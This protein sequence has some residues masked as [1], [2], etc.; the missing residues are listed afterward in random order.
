MSPEELKKQGEKWLRGEIQ[1]KSFGDVVLNDKQTEFVNAK[2][3][4]TLM[5]GGFAS[6]KT[7]AFIIKLILLCLWF[8]GNRILLGRKTR[9]AVEQATLP[10]FFDICPPGI[11]QH[12]IGP[13]IIEFYNGS[14]ILLWGLDALQ[15]GAGQ[16]I[17]KAEQ[18]IKS[19]NLGAVFIDQLEEVE[20][21]VFEAL[22]GRLRRDVGFNQMNLTTN[23]ANFWAYDYFKA[24]PRKF[25]RL[26]E[27]SMMD[28]K[29]HLSDSFI[30]S[31]LE[32]PELYV[33]RYVYGEWSPDTLIQG[34]VFPEDYIKQQAFHVKKPIR[35]FDGIKIYEEPAHAE[36]QIGL[37][38]SEGSVDPGSIKVV[39]KDTGEEVA[40]YTAFVP[41]T[42][43]A[44]KAVQLGIMYSLVKKPLIVPESQG[45]GTAVIEHL[46]KLGYE[47]IYEREVF[48][49]REKRSTKK[50]GFHTNHASKT[51]LIEHL[52]ELFKKRFPK[53]RD[54]QTLEEMKTFIYSDEA[55]LKGAG[56][57]TG[58]HD[59]RVM[60]L[61]L[62]YWNIEAKTPKERNILERVGQKKK[63]VVQY[64]YD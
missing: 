33:K 19:L 43:L 28:N 2:D 27:T 16:D 46:K 25:T 57:Q 24:N 1:V 4:F 40:D 6:G 34:G 59:D 35:E 12:K 29:K 3:R 42:H 44:E 36:Y 54:L 45:G 61:L 21:R 41:L 10:D 64:Q 56:A 51:Q 22:D 49:Q 60:S 18:A 47:R 23:P 8:P 11:Y 50:L 58:F 15:S 52:N 20:Y 32:K 37:D 14:Q 31:Q 39:N 38:P 30:E 17:K 13:G 63:S 62:A 55:H 7:H 26:I 48:N 9:Q 5:S 53:I